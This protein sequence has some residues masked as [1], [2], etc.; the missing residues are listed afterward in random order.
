M[1][2]GEGPFI[3]LY[4]VNTS[5][6]TIVCAYKELKRECKSCP[7]ED[8]F[9]DVCT[10]FLDHFYLCELKAI[11]YKTIWLAVQH[12]TCTESTCYLSRTRFP[13]TKFPSPAQNSQGPK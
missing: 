12:K 7:T 11:V 8:P 4:R 9:W 13:G 2:T 5:T 3:C 6:Y 1:G 10:S